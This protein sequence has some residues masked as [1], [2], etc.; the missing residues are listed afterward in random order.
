M[1]RRY[2]VGKWKI[3]YGTLPSVIF[4]RYS[5]GKWKITYGTLP[6]VIFRRYSVGKWYLKVGAYMYRENYLRNTSVGNFP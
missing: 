1:F 5:V 2:S 4:R 6:S 3:I